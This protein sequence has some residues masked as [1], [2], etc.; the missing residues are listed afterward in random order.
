MKS[1][2]DDNNAGGRTGAADR[3]LQNLLFLT[4]NNNNQ[5]P[6]IIHNN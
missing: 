2:D 5:N 1:C 4:L 3:I 6:S